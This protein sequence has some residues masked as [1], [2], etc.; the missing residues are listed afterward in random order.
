MNSDCNEIEDDVME[1]VSNNRKM[2]DRVE[3]LLDAG[4]RVMVNDTYGWWEYGSNTICNMKAFK[5]AQIIMIST[6]NRK[7]RHIP[8]GVCTLYVLL[9]EG[10][11]K[12]I[13]RKMKL[14]K[15]YKGSAKSSSGEYS[16]I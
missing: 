11:P 7:F 2:K 10:E 4:Y 15:L 8:Y 13:H 14:K 3:K 1:M 5:I 16:I 12:K 9:K 6:Y